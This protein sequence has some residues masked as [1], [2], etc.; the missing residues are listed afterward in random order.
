MARKQTSQAWWRRGLRFGLR[1][2][3][4]FMLLSS[5]GFGWLAKERRRNEVFARLRKASGSA[6]IDINFASDSLHRR[7]SRLVLGDLISQEIESMNLTYAHLVDED[8]KGLSLFTETQ[9]L[10]LVDNAITDEGLRSLA[11]ITNL[12]RLSIGGQ[13]AREVTDKGMVHLKRFRKLRVL[14]LRKTGVRGIGLKVLAEMPNL[15]QLSLWDSELDRNAVE[16]LKRCTQL[17]K[18]VV[19]R[20]NLSKADVKTIRESLPDCLVVDDV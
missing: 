9:S 4:I 18:L 12:R 11:G 3:L 19:G 2:L 8:M 17:K 13:Y 20:T 10:T 7:L 6:S 16:H 5:L 14:E 15:E 1:T